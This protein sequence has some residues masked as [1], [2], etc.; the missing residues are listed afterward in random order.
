MNKWISRNQKTY[1]SNFLK[2]MGAGC[3]YKEP[4]ERPFNRRERRRRKRRE[5]KK[6]RATQ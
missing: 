1:K 3:Q 2:Y 4:I 5:M 6:A